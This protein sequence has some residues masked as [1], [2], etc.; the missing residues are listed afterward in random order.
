M[1][2]EESKELISSQHGSYEE[3]PFC[4]NDTRPDKEDIEGSNRSGPVV[5][6]YFLDVPNVY[7]I[8]FEKFHNPETKTGIKTVRKCDSPQ[9]RHSFNVAS[10][11]KYRKH[12]SEDTQNLTPIARIGALSFNFLHTSMSNIHRYSSPKSLK[13]FFTHNYRGVRR[14]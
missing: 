8:N 6:S 10:V 1:E 4:L 14:K 5:G 11:Q 12:S 7:E 2:L 3:I 9:R 13:S